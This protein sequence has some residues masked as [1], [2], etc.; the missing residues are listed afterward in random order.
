MERRGTARFLAFTILGSTSGKLRTHDMKIFRRTVSAL[1]NTGLCSL[2][3]AILVPVCP[4]SAELGGDEASVL[5]DVQQMHAVRRVE[6][7]Q[8]YTL[9]EI[10]T[11]PG[12]VI[13]EFVSPAGKVFAVSWQGPATPDFSQILGSYYDQLQQAQANRNGRGPLILHQPELVFHS[14]GHMRS[15]SGRAYV[16]AL[17]PQ[18]VRVETIR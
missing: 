18:G 13:R 15:F 11:P 6:R 17:V 9:H 5:A 3:L 4:A 16:P 7:T 12:T 8:T 10:H 2:V 14:G 1:W